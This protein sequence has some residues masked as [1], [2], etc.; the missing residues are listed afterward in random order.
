MLFKCDAIV[1]ATTIWNN[2]HNINNKSNEML[3]KMS[4]PTQ[5]HIY[6]WC[7]KQIIAKFTMFK[8]ICLFLVTFPGDVRVR[9]FVLILFSLFIWIN[10]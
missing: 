5:F 3:A 6:Q 2:S 1:V 10:S 7:G 4:I 9:V 8:M